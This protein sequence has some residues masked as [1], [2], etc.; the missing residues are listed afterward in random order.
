MQKNS[1]LDVW[2]G[3]K[4]T[5]ESY[6]LKKQM[7]FQNQPPEIEKV[8]LEISENWQGSTCARVSISMKLQVY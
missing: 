1:I 8:F 3:S 4:Y 5:S 6:F 7:S 2:R